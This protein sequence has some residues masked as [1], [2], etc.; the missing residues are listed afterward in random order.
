MAIEASRQMADPDSRIVGF[1]LKQVSIKRALI[2]PETREG[3]ET[4]L[5]MSRMDQSALMDTRIWK[6]FEVAS[7]DPV[8]NEWIEHCTG[9]IKVDYEKKHNPVDGEKVAA[10]E[11]YAWRREL[12]EV[13]EVCQTPIDFSKSYED[14]GKIGL[15]FGPLFR[16]L[17]DVKLSGQNRGGPTSRT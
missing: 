17:S 9:Y 4:S 5:T 12:Q 6:R 3:V 14:F 1:K 2:I 13:S 15:S 16:N 11:N 7:F 8:G 10:E